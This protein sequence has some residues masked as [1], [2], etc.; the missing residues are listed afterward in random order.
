MAPTIA[1]LDEVVEDK[2]KIETALISVFDKAGMEELG[3]FLAERKVHILST[4]GTAAKLRS[5]GCT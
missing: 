2:V 3:S 5:L 4:G 1:K